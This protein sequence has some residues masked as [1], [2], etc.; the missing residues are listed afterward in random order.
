MPTKNSKYIKA[1][2]KRSPISG[3][4]HFAEP[5]YISLNFKDLS[6]K[7]G[8]TPECWEKIQLL[9]EKIKFLRDIGNTDITTLKQQKRLV[10]YDKFPKKS[11][12]F[13]P[14][15]LKGNKWARLRIRGKIRVCGYVIGTK[16]YVVFLD[17]DHEFYPSER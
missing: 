11:K 7:Q 1:K 4:S 12:F 17:K 6:K 8:Q 10:I 16:F 3:A 15:H 14:T 13:E 5:K 2:K 9:S